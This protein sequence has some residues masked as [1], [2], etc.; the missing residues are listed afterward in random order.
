MTIDNLSL[1]GVGFF[2]PPR[3]RIVRGQ[4]VRIVLDGVTGGARVKVVRPEAS[5]D[6]TYYGLAFGDRDMLEVARRLIG[7]FDAAGHRPDPDGP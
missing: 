2:S 3:P 6:R 7:A 5:G 4:A 1:S